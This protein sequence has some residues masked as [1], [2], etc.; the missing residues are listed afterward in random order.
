MEWRNEYIKLTKNK[1][2]MYI[3]AELVHK[4]LKTKY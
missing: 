4:G 3:P 1:I 2:F